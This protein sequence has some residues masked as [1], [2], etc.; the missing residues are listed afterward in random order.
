MRANPLSI[1][2]GALFLAYPLLVYCGLMFSEPRVAALMLVLLASTRFALV[3]PAT[4]NKGLA[5]RITLALAAAM[6][7]G[8]LV[9]TPPPL[10]QSRASSSNRFG[11]QSAT[12]RFL[13]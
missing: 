11:I 3:K 1:V 8:F 9:C 5:P 2:L 12:R 6:V 4:T 7:I 10:P 13:V